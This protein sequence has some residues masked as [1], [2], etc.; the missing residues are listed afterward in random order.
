M[1]IAFTRGV[2]RAAVLCLVVT[3]TL[4]SVFVSR[5]AASTHE[6]MT[7]HTVHVVATQ[8]TT[9]GGETRGFHSSAPKTIGGDV[10]AFAP[11]PS[12]STSTS[13]KP[14]TVV[15]LHG[16][17]GKAANGCPHIKNGA[18]DVGWLVCPK[19]DNAEANGTA[20]WSI[21]PTKP[22]AVVTHAL[23][24]AEAEGASAEPGVAVGFSQGGY[25]TLDLV[26]S[27]KVKFRGLVLIAAPEAHPSA[28]K[29]HAAGVRRVVLAAGYRDAAYAPLKEDA[30]RLEREGMEVRF[31]SLGD[32]GHTYAA[33]D[34]TALHDAIV[35]AA[36]SSTQGPAAPAPRSQP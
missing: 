20:T 24:A 35:W 23:E 34:P 16:I 21:D 28:E 36:G 5:A 32:V 1:S 30:K 33:E 15:Y 7:A 13:D 3:A 27:G 17:H 26:K 2:R 9:L 25:V 29:L 6:T 22:A 11:A 18:S 31:V 12:T 8:K 19:A 14:L 4:G 10:L